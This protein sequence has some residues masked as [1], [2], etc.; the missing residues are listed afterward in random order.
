MWRLHHERESRYKEPTSQ[1]IPLSLSP[2]VLEMQKSLGR[3]QTMRRLLV[4]ELEARQRVQLLRRTLG[5][6]VV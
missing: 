5:V 4:P 6:R 2:Q 1:L 3:R